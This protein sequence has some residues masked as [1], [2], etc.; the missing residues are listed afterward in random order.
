MSVENNIFGNS[1]FLI[2][3]TCKINI[4]ITKKLVFICK[5]VK[6]LKKYLKI[7]NLS[8]TQINEINNFNNNTKIKYE[9]LSKCEICASNKLNI[10]FINDRY[11]IN[12]KTSICNN[13][14]FIFSNPRMT[15]LSAEI[16]YNSDTYRLIYNDNNENIDRKK[17]LENVIKELE[18]YKSPNP[19]TPN[20]D[21]Y[22]SNLYF[23]FINFEI[24]DFETVLDI[25]CGKGK[26]L[27]DF[28]SLG[29]KTYGIEP[30]KVYHQAHKHL[31]LNIKLG[32]INDIKE[33]YDLV[34]LS[35]VLE[36]LNDLE[37]NVVHLHNI[38]NK[39]LF[40]EVPGNVNKL[41]SI[42]NAHN[43]YFSINSLNYFF[44]NNKFNL[45]K[46]EYA[47]D[48]N[49]LFALYE[50]TETKSHFM[51]DK[52]SELRSTKK[53]I[54]NYLFKYLIIKLL[55]LMGIANITKKFIKFIK[56]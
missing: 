31:G 12:Q 10:L 49:F 11:G 47:K 27:I 54:R 36:H 1:Y 44:L 6:V 9:K 52:V 34:I 5:E 18:N 7:E 29:K 25:G 33:K 45:I 26:K 51:F 50:K 17:L 22:Y 16:F 8:A 21:S 30:S 23:D 46:I 15:K 38:T 4:N 55:S 35:H 53:I 20:F 42:Q 32:F 56:K 13:C 14:G 39:Y 2:E 19:K 48:N 28:N 37:K 43:Y 24:K 41:Q 40:I 3:K